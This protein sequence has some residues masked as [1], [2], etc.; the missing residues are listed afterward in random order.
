MSQIGLRA[1]IRDKRHADPPAVDQGANLPGYKSRRT[2]LNESANPAPCTNLT[3]WAVATE[4]VEHL[5]PRA[6]PQS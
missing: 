3:V 5:Q 4:Q 1:A 2:G 6:E